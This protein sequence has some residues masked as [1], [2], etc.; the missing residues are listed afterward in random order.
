MTMTRWNP[1]AELEEMRRKMD[2]LLEKSSQ[3]VRPQELPGQSWQP[4]AEIYEDD[5]ELVIEMDLPG[6]LQEDIQVRIE[7]HTLM[8]HGERKPSHDMTCT[9]QRSERSYGQF[10]REF[11]LPGNVDE[12]LTQASCEQGVLQV[13]LR[14][15]TPG[16]P[17][18][19]D[20]EIK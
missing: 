19:I 17:L 7:E 12:S 20:V 11:A 14:K 13:R 5:S 16:V 2:A 4:A 3:M 15:K 10:S 1:I 8:I 6:I 18:R 9:T